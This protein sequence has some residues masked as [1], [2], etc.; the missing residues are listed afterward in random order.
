MNKKL[1]IFIDC[2]DTLVDESSETRDERGV[3]TGAE[4]IEGAKEA[5]LELY[6]QGH[7]IAL[8]ADGLVES[9]QNI[10]RSHGIEHV[11][12]A[13]VISE[14]LGCEKPHPLMF[15]QA[16]EKMGLTPDDA[17]RIVMVGNNLKRDV[18]GANRMGICSILLSYSPRYRMRPETEEEIPD[19]VIAMPDELP[20]LVAQLEQQ[21]HNR[22]ILDR[23]LVAGYP[24]KQ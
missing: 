17:C 9:F 16:M 12:E 4:L 15:R 18:L 21:L 20:G 19:Y 22:R 23:E 24:Y 14:S 5:L 8:V 7:R 13:Q 11:F 6:Q 1:I 10:I 3:V 2:G